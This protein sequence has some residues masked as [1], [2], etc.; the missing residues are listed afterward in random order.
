MAVTGQ[1]SVAA[2]TQEHDPERNLGR[3]RAA[4]LDV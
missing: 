3:R 4:A 2:D 1:F